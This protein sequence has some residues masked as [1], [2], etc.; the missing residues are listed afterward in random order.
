MLGFEFMLVGRH[1]KAAAAGGGGPEGDGATLF[2]CARAAT[3]ALWVLHSVSMNVI[4][5]VSSESTEV[6]IWRERSALGSASALET[7][8]RFTRCIIVTPITPISQRM[9]KM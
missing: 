8:E 5:V 3:M 4:R 7:D 1:C 2:K 9:A 6:A